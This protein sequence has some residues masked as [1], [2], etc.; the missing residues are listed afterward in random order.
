M[1]N[2]NFFC[3]RKMEF[4]EPIT[5]GR[6][7]DIL[8]DKLDLRGA[9]PVVRNERWYSDIIHVNC[10]CLVFFEVIHDSWTDQNRCLRLKYLTNKKNSSLSCLCEPFAVWSSLSSDRPGYSVSH[11]ARP[12]SYLFYSILYC[13]FCKSP[14]LSLNILTSIKCQR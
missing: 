3:I 6:V 4:I 1:N 2:V 9:R 7:L 10:G 5:P 11:H 12:N 8:V 13:I 14:W